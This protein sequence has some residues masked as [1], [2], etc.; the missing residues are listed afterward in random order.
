VEHEAITRWWPAVATAILSTGAFEA[1]ITDDVGTWTDWLTWQVEGKDWR[2][3]TAQA[4]DGGGGEDGGEGAGKGGG[5]AVGESEGSFQSGS[6]TSAQSLAAALQAASPLASLP[7]YPRPSS[8]DT[9]TTPL[10]AGDRVSA[11]YMAQHYGSSLANW[12]TGIITAVH[13][14]E[15]G[16]VYDIEFD[17]GDR[18]KHVPRHF[19]QSIGQC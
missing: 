11:K 6:G 12:Y 15:A 14:T 16:S 17:D 9:K 13:A 10:V 2:R 19:I 1:K 18:E 3:A 5:H 8:L 4:A 7:T